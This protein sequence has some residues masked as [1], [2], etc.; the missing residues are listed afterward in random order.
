MANHGKKAPLTRMHEGDRV[1]I[2][3]P[4][5]TFPGGKPFKAI[6][7]VGAIT[8]AAPEPSDVIPDGYRLRAE[9]RWIEPLPLERIRDHLPMSK[10][11]FGCFDLPAADA[12]AIWAMV[13]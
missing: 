3:S 12:D 8:G 13:G 4:T 6:A 2:Y 11:R 5:T 1:L 10:L 9:L 7:I